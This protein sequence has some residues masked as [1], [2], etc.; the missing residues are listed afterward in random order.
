ME[1]NGVGCFKEHTLSNGKTIKIRYV[2]PLL[3]SKIRRLFPD[4]LPPVRVIQSKIPGVPPTEE[5]DYQDATYQR[6]RIEVLQQRIQAINDFAW[7]Y[8][9]VGVDPPEDDE[10]K[11][12]VQLE[13]YLP[14]IP[15]REGPVGRR[16]DWLE[17][18]LLANPKDMVDVEKLVTEAS[19]VATEEEVAA[20]EESF[21]PQNKRETVRAHG[22]R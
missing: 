18:V 11:A 20:A 19:R 12:S 2:P 3:A 17:Y 21:R 22:K 6:L 8:A 16:L 13:L 1:T 7:N 15:W 5:F 14:G 4:P 10:W 9:V